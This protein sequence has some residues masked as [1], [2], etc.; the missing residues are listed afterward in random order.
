MKKGNLYS[1]W[2]KN[3]LGELF[4]WSKERKILFTYNLVILNVR[5]WTGIYLFVCLFFFFFAAL[6]V[7]PVK[8]R[9]RCSMVMFQPGILM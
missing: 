4:F 8:C 1:F 6:N 7:I 2:Y 5:I 3:L 9:K